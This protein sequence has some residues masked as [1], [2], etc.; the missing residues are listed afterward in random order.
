MNQEFFSPLSEDIFNFI[1]S[2]CEEFAA[3]L[4]FQE[5]GELDK[6]HIQ[7]WCQN[8]AALGY[9][10]DVVKDFFMLNPNQDEAGLEWL[11]SSIEK[12]QAEKYKAYSCAKQGCSQEDIERCFGKCNR[13][14]EGQI[15]N[16]VYALVSRKQFEEYQSA[17][18]A[19]DRMDV[20]L[21]KV[22]G[23]NKDAVFAEQ[24]LKD[25]AIL[26]KVKPE[27]YEEILEE[28]TDKKVDIKKLE[29]KLL[30]SV[31]ESTGGKTSLTVL[32]PENAVSPLLLKYTDFKSSAD[33]LISEKGWLYGYDRG[34]EDYVPICNFIPEITQK[35]IYDDDIEK[36]V[37]LG[38]RLLIDGS[39]ATE[40]VILPAAELK[41]DKNLYK[42]FGDMMVI[43]GHYDLIRTVAF[44]A[45]KKVPTTVINYSLGWK[46]SDVTGKY[47]FCFS[48]ESLGDDTVH[49]ADITE[50]HGYSM[51]NTDGIT[52]E[53][54]YAAY[55]ELENLM[56]YK[57]GANR[58]LCTYSSGSILNAKLMELGIPPRYLLWIAGLTGSFKTEGGKLLCGFFGKIENPAANFQDTK[59]SIEK[60]MHLCKDCLLLID[61]FCPSSSAAEERAKVDKANMVIRNI[62]DRVSRG[63]AKSNMTLSKEYRPRGN[64]IIT[65]E[66]II[67][68]VSTLARNLLITLTRG[69]ITSEALSSVQN[70]KEHLNAFMKE[71]IKYVKDNVMDECK[72][73]LKEM[74]ISYR[75]EAQQTKHH[76]RL[77]ETVANLRLCQTVFN[78]FLLDKE[79]ITQEEF[80]TRELFLKDE[81]GKIVEEQNELIM[82]EDPADLFLKAVSE[83]IVAGE[84]SPASALKP[85]RT[86]SSKTI[87]FFEGDYYYFL[88]TSLYAK[89]VEYY[90]RKDKNFVLSE[91]GVWN[92]LKER[93]ILELNPSTDGH[94]DY[95]INKRIGKRNTR[96][97]VIKKA[98]VE[99]Y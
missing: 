98:I 58:V 16:S 55:K 11:E 69:D 7:L 21:D 20:V 30:T 94:A 40:E 57:P 83:M 47:A 48:G 22:D 18:E 90:R 75:N 14:S 3:S 1:A 52:L 80:D 6:E 70:K 32:T 5:Q 63:R 38:V 4:D 15:T 9:D 64:V 33:V 28:L 24:A 78:T 53:E 95:K 79:L 74:F 89:V 41:S 12:W 91:R 62:G 59:A 19:T 2:R 27:K 85:D 49:V 26:Q 71:Y 50:L 67:G 35:Y 73:D 96:V 81:L 34:A 93:G 88:P 17:E 60:K 46:R 8:L 45:A 56:T 44:E 82:A 72:F 86:L 37:H 36:T 99:S 76:R 13:N 43:Y 10:A 77:A 54:A 42:Y 84:L 31:P 61:D 23:G 66:D 65:G 29:K 68:G 39:V 92:L 87:A 25:L 51:Q 97:I